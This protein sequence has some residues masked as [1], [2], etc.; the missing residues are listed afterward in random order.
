MIRLASFVFITIF[1]CGCGLS[2][3]ATLSPSIT[4][5]LELAPEEGILVMGLNSD[6]YIKGIHIYGNESFIAYF[7]KNKRF[8]YKHHYL[9]INLAAGEYK[10]IQV[11]LNGNYV[12][13]IHEF[14]HQ[15][16]WKVQ[17]KPGKISYI[18]DFELELHVQD[19]ISFTSEIINRSSYALEFLE[20]NYPGLMK[21]YELVYGGL[22]EDDFFSLAKQSRAK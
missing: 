7:E 19:D 5:E 9:V 16:I 4:N 11:D 14:D 15:E 21:K 13:R 6:S 22:I 3:R 12:L 8:E 17:V 20:E 1:F 18:G 10:F 2:K